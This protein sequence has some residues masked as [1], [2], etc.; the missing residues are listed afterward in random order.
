MASYDCN[1]QLN[2]KQEVQVRTEMNS[3]SSF[4][5]MASYDSNTQQHIK[6]ALQAVFTSAQLHGVLNHSVRSV[7]GCLRC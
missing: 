1:T 4:V 5:Q 7:Q 3:D 6:S 2:N